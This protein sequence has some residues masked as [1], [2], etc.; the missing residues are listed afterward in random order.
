MEK[1]PKIYDHYWISGIR[2][3][4]FKKK[5]ESKK[6]LS[7]NEIVTYSPYSVNILCNIYECFQRN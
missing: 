7:I 6:L 5:S 4:K 1:K 3:F 2:D